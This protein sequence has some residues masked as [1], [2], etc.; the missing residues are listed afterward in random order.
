MWIT[1][2]WPNIRPL[3]NEKSGAPRQTAAGTHW[4]ALCLLGAG[5]EDH[6]RTVVYESHRLRGSWS[7][8]S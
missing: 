5:G 4:E 1:S 2:D 8:F 7:K 6:L 3:P